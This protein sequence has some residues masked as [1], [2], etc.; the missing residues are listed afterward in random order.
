MYVTVVTVILRC[1]GTPSCF[2]ATFTKGTCI[3]LFAVFVDDESLPEWGL[4]LKERICSLRE[5]MLFFRA[6][7][8]ELENKFFFRKNFLPWKFNFIV[9]VKVAIMREELQ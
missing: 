6:A 7:T 9:S 2:S 1:M 5:Q 4:L 3:F 8:Y